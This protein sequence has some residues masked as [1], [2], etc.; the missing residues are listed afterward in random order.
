MIRASFF[1][2]FMAAAGQCVHAGSFVREGVNVKYQHNNFIVRFQA[3][4]GGAPLDVTYSGTRLVE[5]FAGTGFQTVI[6]ADNDLTQ[7]GHNGIGLSPI[8]RLNDASTTANAYY[9]RETVLN[10]STYQLTGYLPYFLDN[11]GVDVRFPSGSEGLWIGGD[12]TTGTPL[13]FTPKPGHAGGIAMVGRQN[14]VGFGPLAE[15]PD[16]RVAFQVNVTLAGASSDAVAGVY[17]RRDMSARPLSNDGVYYSPGYAL[18]VNAGGVVNLWGPHGLLY[19]SGSQAS[20]KKSVLS[21][22]GIKLEIRT[23]NLYRSR[24]E[25][26][27]NGSLIST[28]DVGVDPTPTL[29]T[30]TGFFATASSGRV[31]FLDRRIFDMSKE[32]VMTYTAN[33]EESLNVD[34]T[35]RPAPFV[36]SPIRIFGAT[37][38]AFL[39]PQSPNSPRNQDFLNTY[40]DTT[41][42]TTWAKPMLF[43]SGGVNR[44]FVGTPTRR[45][46]L[47]C[48]PRFALIDGIPSPA[49]HA[50]IQIRDRSDAGLKQATLHV[51]ANDPSDYDSG[52][53]VNEIRFSTKWRPY[54]SDQP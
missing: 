27:I 46:G 53:F 1:V 37:Q 24:Q 18:L 33:N 16:G 29:G 45:L 36:A 17:Y 8:A 38:Q 12:Y 35:V 9:L 31:G 41:G 32:V 25:I 2:A 40:S 20:Y 52:R 44:L 6:Y 11:Q 10:S 21:P 13:W 54:W 15:I 7:A 30:A 23:H 50:L 47:Q 5:N 22:A 14:G 42:W 34:V 49:A 3:A 43:T 39:V 51:S 28:I 19:N 48:V 26:W 4:F